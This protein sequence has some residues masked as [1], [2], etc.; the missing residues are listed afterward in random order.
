MS[1]EDNTPHKIAILATGDEISKGD[2]IN[3]N[4]QEIALRLTNRGMN[5]RIHVV[6]PDTISELELAMAFLLKSH[7][8]LII[9]GGLGPTSDDLT[10]F[11]LSKIIDKPLVFDET[12]WNKICARLKRFGYGVPPESNRQQALFPEG[13][14]IIQNP[15]GTAAGCLIKLKNQIITMLPGPPRECL[16]M[17]DNS[18]LPELINAGYQHVSYH[19]SWFLF[20][21]SEGKIGE[22]L[23]LLAKPYDCVTGYRLFYP[24]IEFKLHSNNAEDYAKLLPIIEKAIQPYLISTGEVTASALLQDY[25]A[26]TNYTLDIHDQATGGSLQAWIE[27]PQ[28]RRHLHFYHDS[29]NFNDANIQIE[30]QGLNEFWEE[31]TDIL[32]AHLEIIFS[33]KKQQKKVEV[34]IPFRGKRVVRY[35]VEFICSKIY[36]F[37]QMQETNSDLRKN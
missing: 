27:T 2:I 17:L 34:E 9:T 10:R 31:K 1:R 7:D 4:S 6:V 26:N 22:E 20:G 18:V 35:A 3:S 33:S 13:A 14:M 16:P 24:Y 23:D 8:A 15:N 21:A 37:L 11:A 25:L 28:T 12:T 19:K 30:I 5:V 29:K 36:E 32:Y